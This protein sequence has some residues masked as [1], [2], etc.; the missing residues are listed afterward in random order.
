M[1]IRLGSVAAAGGP[2]A[3]SPSQWSFRPADPTRK[4]GVAFS[5]EPAVTTSFCV[6]GPFYDLRGG[7][8]APLPGVGIG[9]CGANAS[10]IVTKTCA[11]IEAEPIQVKAGPDENYYTE[12]GAVLFASY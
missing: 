12:F 3:T 7:A 8:W 1:D 6:D 4:T 10:A 5:L 2:G 9:V 11:R